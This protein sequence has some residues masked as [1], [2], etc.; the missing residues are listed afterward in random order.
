MS[1]PNPRTV[2]GHFPSNPS[3][4]GTGHILRVIASLRG[5]K[6]FEFQM[7]TGISH[8]EAM[9]QMSR[10]D[11]IIDQ[12]TPF[13]VYGMVAVEAMALGKVVISSVDRRLY[14]RCPIVPASPTNFEDRLQDLL[15]RKDEWSGLGMA[16]RQYVE[17]VHNPVSVAALLVHEY[18]RH[19]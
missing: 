10:C 4:K 1:K 14:D 2:V 13:G 18:E 8:V 9:R 7:S 19:L 11:I 17:R 16:G 12:L 5:R 3:K 15:D 6:D